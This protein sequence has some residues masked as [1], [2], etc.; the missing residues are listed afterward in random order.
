MYKKII[1]LLIS[2]ILVACASVPVYH[3][4]SESEFDKATIYSG[5]DSESRLRWLVSN[6]ST[7]LFIRLDTDNPV[8]IKKIVNLGMKIHID[9]LAKKKDGMFINYP[10]F[11]TDE[12]TRKDEDKGI[13]RYDNSNDKNLKLGLMLQ[14]SSSV[15]KFT[16]NKQIYLYN[17]FDENADIIANIKADDSGNIQYF[18]KIPLELISSINLKVISICIDIEGVDIETEEFKNNDSDNIFE[19]NNRQAQN[20]GRHSP[21]QRSGER[22]PALAKD[23]NIWFRVVLN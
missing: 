19:A 3:S 18:A 10:I 7:N 2:I 9:T 8:T 13:S 12:L 17:A 5:Y 22:Q 21:T 15:V 1:F 6:D 11:E 20:R 14:K 23:V 16:K 4:I